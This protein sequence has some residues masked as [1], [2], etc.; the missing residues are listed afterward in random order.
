M[1]IVNIAIVA[2]SL[3]AM[4]SCS[5]KNE[6]KNAESATTE[7]ASDATNGLKQITF[8]NEQ[9]QLAG[10][11]TGKITLVNIS[12]M[13]KL[14][15]IID[16]SPESKAIV[17]A[18]LG[19][20]IRSAGYIPGQAVSKGQVVAVLESKEFIDLQQSYLQSKSEYAFLTQEYER[21]QKLRENDVNALKTFQ[22]VTADLESTKVQME[23]L[24]HTLLLA[25]INP[26]SI[27]ADN[28]QRTANLYAPISGYVK[29]NN[30]K[31]GSFVSPNDVL[32]E[33]IN[34][35][36]LYINLNAFE[37]NINSLNKGQNIKFCL[38]SENQYNRNAAI[39]VV[40]KSASDDKTI[41]INC[42][43]SEKDKDGLLPG[44]YV[45]AWVETSAK[46]QPTVPN[47]AIINRDGD[48]YIILETGNDTTDRNFV[49]QKIVKGITQDGIT[50]ITVPSSVDIGK[51]KVVV[52]NAYTIFSALANSEEE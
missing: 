2:L 23:G 11:E 22:R 6:S 14:N 16:V 29:T 17:S 43:I 36:N 32:L 21:Q 33:I 37:Q 12:G 49:F 46:E 24:E 38:A 18:P 15:G 10:I 51:A 52:K 39:V 25:G 7:S 5:S 47:E 27:S 26:K 20:Y 45:K 42:V 30:M 8:T 34:T 1:K 9:Y 35:N 48:D 28:I 3:I 40:G 41:P 19:G 31:Q 50:A 13:V 4:A 44:M